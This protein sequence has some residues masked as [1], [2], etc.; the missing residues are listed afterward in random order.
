[1]TENQIT[2]ATHL[3]RCTFVPATGTKRFAQSMADC[4]KNAPEYELT[5]KQHQ[6]LCQAV[7]KFRRQIPEAI[8]QIARKELLECAVC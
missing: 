1:M 4:V 8:V 5:P 2:L 7:I 6:Y 3:A